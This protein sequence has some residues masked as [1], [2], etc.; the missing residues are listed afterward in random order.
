MR[1]ETSNNMREPCYSTTI[2]KIPI[3]WMPMWTYDAWKSAGWSFKHYKRLKN[4][5]L[6]VWND[7]DSQRLVDWWYILSLSW[8]ST[9]SIWSCISVKWY[10]QYG[11]LLWVADDLYDLVWVDSRFH[12]VA[13]PGLVGTSHITTPINIWAIMPL[14]M[15]NTARIHFKP[16]RC[17]V[18]SMDV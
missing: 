13:H 16:L 18:D 12:V 11:E 5:Q 1:I 6:R 9:D 3:Y 10:D 15:L 4:A 17:A 2:R 7:D 8:C 14:T